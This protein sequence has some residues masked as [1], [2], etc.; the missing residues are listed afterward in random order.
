[1][2]AAY[3]LCYHPGN[4]CLTGIIHKIYKISDYSEI[5]ALC[6]HWSLTS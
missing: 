2:Q 3:I 5:K 6:M 1:M 4:L